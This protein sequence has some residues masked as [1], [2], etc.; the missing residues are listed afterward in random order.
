MKLRAGSHGRV[1]VVGANFAG[2]T[3]AQHLSTSHAVTVIDAWPWFEW[4]PN[5][6]EL[7]SGVKRPEGLR[8]S[9]P[10][11]VMRAGHR[12]L[13]ATVASI[14][15]RAGRLL[16]TNNRRVDFD[17]CV[18]AVG[19]VN[20]SFGVPGADRYAM[21]FKTVDE[22][23]A[24]GRKLAALVRQKARPSVVIVGGGLEGVEALGEV[25]RRYRTIAH[26]A[27]HVVEGAPRL[28]PGAPA[29]I[30]AM[31]RERCAPHNVRFHAG[32]RVDEVTR[33]RV[34]LSSGVTLRSDL[35]MWTGGTTAPEL[36]LATGLA[37]RP[38]QWAP[39]T[40]TLQSRHFENVF[41][42]GDAAALPK[43]ISKQ[44]Y[45]AM[46]MGEHAAAGVERLL[47]GRRPRSFHPSTKPMLISLGDLDTYLVAGK[48]VIA[49]SALAA[50][51][52]SVFELTMAQIDPPLHPS[53]LM[54][55]AARATGG[56]RELALPALTSWEAVQRLAH[57]R[58]TW[59]GRGQST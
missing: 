26:L 21:K 59:N 47:A 14:D 8:L 55:L 18:V 15:A 6:H 7:V 28:L 53:S 35:T 2:L 51:K 29:A 37:D 36:L 42:I 44:A 38:K 33:G 24:I 34:R 58:L 23:H 40:E 43:P 19:G 45:Y 13:R 52:E 22:C 12:F 30:D 54:R 27:V 48:M 57:L 39:V 41:V 32:T 31:V 9:R 20:D 5:I 11:L 56:I 50:A 1:V 4:L 10:H 25:L 17:V 49:G 16:T 46:Q 3:A